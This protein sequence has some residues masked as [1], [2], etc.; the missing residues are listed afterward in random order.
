M[1]PSATGPSVSDKALEIVVVVRLGRVVQRWPR[2]EVVFGRGGKAERHVGR[3]LSIAGGEQFHPR[4]QSF[5]DIPAQRCKGLVADQVSLVQNHQVGA[6]E[7]IAKYLFERVVVDERRVGG[8]LARHCRGIVG[9]AAGGERRGIDHR[10]YAVDGRAGADLRPG[11]GL[12]QRLWQCQA[13]G[14]D[15]DVLGWRWALEQPGQGRQKIVGHGAAQAAIGQ[16]DD[17]VLAASLVAAAE[18]QFAVDAEFAEFID[19]DREPP[20]VSLRQQMAHKARLAGAE[21]AGDDRRR[22][23]PHG[24]G[25]LQNKRQAGGDKHDAIGE[26]RD[27]LIEPPGSV[28]EAAA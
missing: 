8:A 24:S 13:R 14:L 27:F 20:P 2:S 3:H 26:R 23:A 6:G 9:E 17:V 4:P 18:Q 21:K 5:F 22:D 10:Q 11:E 19:D 28:A 15:Q 12:H 25:P 16:L 1:A 7:L